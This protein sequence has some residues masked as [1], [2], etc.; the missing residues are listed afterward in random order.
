MSDRCSIV[1]PVHNRAGLTKLCLDSILAEPPAALLEIIVVDDA[2][3]DDTA[4]LLASYGDAIRVVHREH[5]GGFAATCNDGA[6]VAHSRYLVFLNNDT[7]PRGGWLDTLVAYALRH[8]R[9][10]VVGS[11]LVFPND[12]VQHAGVVI[13]D[14]GNPLH[15]YSGFSADHP[16]VNKSRRFQAVTAACALVDRAPFWEVGGFDTAFLNC[17]E[18]IDLCLRLAERGFE[19]HYCHESVVEHLE[20]AS[21]GRDPDEVLR[22]AEILRTRWSGLVK[23]DDLDYYLEDGL[24]GL[25]YGD[26]Y[27]I[28]MEVAPE[29]AVLEVEGRSQGADRLLEANSR[30]IVGLLAEAVR[31]TARIAD[32]ELAHPEAKGSATSESRGSE[33]DLS[34]AVLA[35]DQLLLHAQRIESE[36]YA[37]Q[38]NLATTLQETRDARRDAGGDDFAPSEYLGYQA[39]VAAVREIVDRTLPPDAKVAVAS[40]GDEDFLRLQG[41]T[42]SHF[43]QDDS[44]G[45][46]GYYPADS[47]AAI[48]QLEQLRANG[49]Q[50]LMFPRTA[51]WW[52]QHYPE[53]AD[54][55]GKRYS[56]VL[57]DEEVG[58][59]FDLVHSRHAVTQMHADDAASPQAKDRSRGLTRAQ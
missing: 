29:L 8:P 35:H 14:D 5:N 46:S 10:A 40:R 18:D 22:N 12:T 38:A 36:I 45:Y 23:R 1:I 3:T 4:R 7:I 56:V 21:R 57:R 20:S 27:P 42:G 52:L 34:P 24:L 30:Q 53:F 26:M 28:A 6:R 54:Y 50:Y 11:K 32:L 13:R 15:L 2:S 55:L 44:G 59:L 41:R 47:D 31:L 58:L 39:L 33:K 51:T 19:S 37:L 9:A 17:F 25:Q 43:P 48:A 49:V 16:A